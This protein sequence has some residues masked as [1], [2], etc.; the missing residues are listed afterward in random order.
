VDYRT[1]SV[2]SSRDTLTFSDSAVTI[3]A[4]GFAKGYA[5]IETADI[6]DRC[7]ITS[8]LISAG[9]VIGKGRRMNGARW[10]IGIRHPR[11]ENELIATVTLDSGAIFTSGD[12]ENFW[13]H[14]TRRIHHL[15][16]PH[17]G[18]SCTNNQSVTI[19]SQS[20][21]QAKYLA[22]GLFCMPADSIVLFAE[23]RGLNCFV[24]DSAGTT[25]MSSGWKNRLELTKFE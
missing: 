8:Y 2:N 25:F 23:K 1:I 6:L 22:T 11:R 12:Y 10:R 19:E 3:D 9:D 14:G 20:A 17:T 5:L 4:G 13:M 18:L 24:V 7:G 15:F 21:L 16:H